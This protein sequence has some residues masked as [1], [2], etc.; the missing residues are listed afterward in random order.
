MGK[1]EIGLKTKRLALYTLAATQF[2]KIF[3]GYVLQHGNLY[4]TL[5]RTKMCQLGEDAVF[6][7]VAIQVPY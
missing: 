4:K 1:V 2:S 3:W 7:L 5:L 6:L